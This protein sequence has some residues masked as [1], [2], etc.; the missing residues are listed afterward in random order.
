[1]CL[2]LA[3]TTEADDFKELLNRESRA[4]HESLIQ[5]TPKNA[6]PA[7]TAHGSSQQQTSNSPTVSRL[8]TMRSKTSVEK[9]KVKK[10]LKTYGESSQDIFEFHGGSD[11]E[12]DTVPR[13]DLGHK[14]AKSKRHEDSKVDQR[15]SRRSSQDEDVMRRPITS[16]GGDTEKEKNVSVE[17][18]MP[19]PASKSTSFDQSQRSQTNIMTIIA[20]PVPHTS[21]TSKILPPTGTA[22][23]K[24]HSQD[25]MSAPTTPQ[26]RGFDKELS[27]NST[28]SLR[29]D[30]MH[31][32]TATKR[33]SMQT[34]DGPAPSSSASENSPGQTI[35]IQRTNQAIFFAKEVG[36][37]TDDEP[38]GTPIDPNI[39]AV[40]KPVVILPAP[41]DTEG[42]QDELSLSI[43]E[44]SSKSPV[45]PAK[46]SKRKRD[47]K[48]ESFDKLGSDDD[49][50]GIPKEQYQPRPTKRRS[51]NKDGEVFLPTDFSKRP[52]AIGK[53]K[54]KNRRLKTTAFQELLPKDEDEDE[55]DEVKMVPDPRFDIPDKKASKVSAE[56]N[57]PDVERCE[58][59]EIVPPEAQPEQNQA[60]KPSG[61]KKRGRPKKAT[62]NLSEEIAV[63]EPEADI[64]IDDDGAEIEDPIIST[65]AKKSRKKSGTKKT[66]APLFDEQ[67]GNED[68]IPVVEDDP[69]DLPPNV[70]N[71]TSGNTTVQPL[72]EKPASE[73]SPVKANP[74]PETPRKSTTPAPKGPDKHSPISSGKVAYRVGLSKRARIAPLLRIVR[75]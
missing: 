17:S 65:T 6:L 75:K 53:G 39:A 51:G 71:V 70:L 5:P 50:V 26:H 25:P 31:S 52:E 29:F 62:A 60:A 37:S 72:S 54:R 30:S 11:G 3:L 23:S 57:Q 69:E 8:K 46:V 55:D 49:A 2:I 63:D 48:D 21:P 1:M 44:A 67:D 4:A 10:A 20:D 73:I 9:P 27:Q 38:L 58:N 64:D 18:S 41:K 14:A 43:P 13:R 22:C 56:K 40:I 66:S 59:A 16:S 42:T 61:Q 7:T 34:N 35:T 36:S 74:P 47:T 32:N 45:K 24:T 12:L 28:D 19:P 33:V 15:A 68:E